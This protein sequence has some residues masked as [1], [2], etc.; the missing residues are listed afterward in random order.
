MN[1]QRIPA[2]STAHV[3]TA[4]SQPAIVLEAN[5]VNAI[6]AEYNRQEGTARASHIRR[7]EDGSLVL[8]VHPVDVGGRAVPESF[9]G[10]KVRISRE[11]LPPNTCFNHLIWPL[12]APLLDAPRAARRL[13]EFLRSSAYP[14]P[15]FQEP[16]TAV[17]NDRLVLT[18]EKAGLRAA[19]LPTQFAGYLVI[20]R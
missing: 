20:A 10:A 16:G 15:I 19:E 6:F 14:E 17:V 11:Q 18:V 5:R 9:H 2:A 13:R 12:H 8:V 4:A 3:S 1:V 7:S